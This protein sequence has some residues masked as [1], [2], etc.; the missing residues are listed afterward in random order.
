MKR[1]IQDL[2]NLQTGQQLQADKILSQSEA[3]IHTLRRKLKEQQLHFKKGHTD[4][5][6]IS[7]A[8]CYQPVVISGNQNQ[9]YFF[10]HGYESGDCPIK[11]T[12]EYTHEEINRMKYNGAKES[13]RHI[14]L[15]SAIAQALEGAN[16]T[17]TDVRQEARITST[18][19]SKEWRKPDVQAVCGNKHLAFEIQ[20]S[21]TFLDVIIERESFYHSEQIFM[22]W[23]FHKF[24]EGGSR[25]T[26]KDIYYANNRNAY[27]IT[28]KTRER[29]N[30][31]GKLVLE[32][33]YQ[34]PFISNKRIINRWMTQEV[35][36]SDLSFDEVTFRVYYFDYDTAKS[37][38]AE[39]LEEESLARK[40]SDF[41]ERR[42]Q[43]SGLDRLEEDR[44]YYALLKAENLIPTR[45]FDES[46]F[47]EDL[48]QILDALYCTK[49]GEIFAYRYDKWIQV[50]NQVL[51]YH[52]QFAGIFIQALKTY[53]IIDEVRSSDRRGTFRKKLQNVVQGVK[54]K[55][56][57]YEQNLEFR[58]LF[59]VLFPELMNSRE[60]A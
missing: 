54:G 20:L 37:R 2:L 4:C 28:D 56:P 51:E 31:L 53:E 45:F 12:G 46:S 44:R 9:E 60:A 15:K 10:K 5:I 14:E 29:S 38:L 48:K 19:L 32:C 7:C 58:P 50:A 6:S 47:P 43:L 59:S 11:T 33:H 57:K 17:C 26:E 18:G 36:L 34:E 16:S 41:W 13:R 21:T 23:I 22:L 3:K 35:T 39:K 8:L 40:F 30:E 24:S 25:F 55:D 49:K 52:Q 1:R 27:V 42:Q